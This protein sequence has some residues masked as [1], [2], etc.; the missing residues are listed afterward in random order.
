MDRATSLAENSSPWRALAVPRRLVACLGAYAFLGGLVSFLG[1]ALDHSRLTDWDNS[2]ISIQPNTTIAVMGAGAAVIL[3]VYG[4]RIAAAILGGL[5][6]FIGSSVI[7]EHA[8]GIDLG[9]DSLFMFERTWGRVGV[10]FPGRMGPPGATSWTLIGTALLLGSLSRPGTQKR[11]WVVVL[12]TIAATIALLSLIGYAYGVAPLYTLPKLTIIAVQTSSFIFTISLALMLAVPERAPTRWLMEDSAAGMA[13]RRLVPF[14]FLFPIG[15]GWLRLRGQM[16]GLYDVAFGTAMFVLLLIFVLIALLLWGFSTISK[17]ETALLQAQRRVSDTLESITDG[18]ITLD[19]DWRFS[20][21]NFQAERLLQKSRAE[22]MGKNV[23][24]MFPES[25]DSPAYDNLQLAASKRISVEFEDHNLLFDRWYANKAYPIADGSLA[26]YFQDITVRR[27]IQEALR[28]TQEQQS[29]DLMAM[30]R[31]QQLS[32]RLVQTGELGVLLRDI[33]AASADLMATDKGNIQFYNPSNQSLRIMF[34]QGHEQPFLDHFAASG[35]E[36]TSTMAARTLERVLIEDITVEPALEGTGD[37]PVLLAD[38]IRAV[39]STPL[40][41]R[42]GRLLGMLSNHF[43]SQRR[44]AE[45]ELRYLDLLARMASDVI[46]RAHSEE[47]LEQRTRGLELL[48]SELESFSYMIS[49]DLRTPLRSIAGFSELLKIAEGGKLDEE[50]KRY[51]EV[52]SHN[53]NRMEEMIQA[54]LHF[55]QAGREEPRYAVIDIHALASSVVHELEQMYT[56]RPG[57]VVVQTT[58]P[59]YGD[60]TLLRQVLAN[61]IENAI[62]FSRH[63][64]SPRIEVGAHIGKDET[65]YYVQ[66]NG[67]GFDMQHAENLFQVFQRLHTGFEGTGIGLA[68]VKRIVERHG[69]R[70]WAQAKTGAGATFYFALPRVSRYTAPEYALMV[71]PADELPKG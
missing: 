61:L 19:R 38:G 8:T 44:L 33:L 52:I 35:S 42:D 68:L 21:V 37:L 58:P 18:F 28:L 60:G 36:T 5:V 13:A 2:G 24:E 20:Y 3:L 55:S 26:V 34:H 6:A 23:W 67:V 10:L 32:T 56:V 7:F 51:I 69:G 71:R 50:G 1:W 14:V 12:A 47:Q 48:N 66:D 41:G 43:K 4:Y 11:A 16:L 17:H 27:Q 62:K 53:V 25:V 63:V 57:E 15:L 29:D 39:Q 65:V 22:L 64:P 49:H 9:V 46:E 40:I 59:A 70:V 54:L 30:T 31:L 45:R